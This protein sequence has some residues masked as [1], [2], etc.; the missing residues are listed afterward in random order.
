MRENR[1]DSIDILL[2]ALSV[3]IFVIEQWFDP[4][5]LPFPSFVTEKLHCAVIGSYYCHIVAPITILWDIIARS[6]PDTFVFVCYK[7]GTG[8]NWVWKWRNFIMEYNI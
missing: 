3:I 1:L 4:I 6:D 7:S 5:L 2:I 8:N